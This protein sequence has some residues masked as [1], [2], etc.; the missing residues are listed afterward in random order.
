[1]K[2]RNKLL[3]KATVLILSALCLWLTGMA[4]QA[5]ITVVE[6]DVTTASDNCTLLG[7]EGTYYV[8]VQEALDRIN[9]IR[10]EACKEGVISPSTGKPLTQ[11]DYVEIKWSGDLEYIARIRAAEAALTIA[12]TRTNG[13]SCFEIQSPNGVR[14]YAEDL[15]WNWS[16]SMTEAIEQWYEEKEDWINQTEGA[17]TGHYTSMINPRYKYFAMGTFYSKAARY[18]NSTAGEFSSVS[19]LSESPLSCPGECVQMLEFANSSLTN[20]YEI[21]GT[22]TGQAGSTADLSVTTSVQFTKLIRGIYIPVDILWESSDS[23]VASVDA[24]GKVTAKYCGTADITASP[25]GMEGS[26]SVT[27]TVVHKKET[28]EAVDPTCTENGLTEGGHCPV[29]GEVLTAQEEIPAL[30]HKPAAVPGY[31]ATC[32][33]DGLT[34]GTKCSVC[35]EI[36]TE[37]EI[38][39]AT[40]HAWDDGFVTKEP[41]TEKEGVRTFTCETC[42]ETMTE[43]IP[44]LPKIAEIPALSGIYGTK[45]SG[46]TLSGGLV[47]R[48]GEEIPGSWSIEDSEDIPAVGTEASYEVIFAASGEDLIVSAAVTPSISPRNILAE[49][50]SAVFADGA[51]SGLV[52]DGTAKKPAV[53]ITDAAAAITERDYDISYEQNVI[54]GEAL[55]IIT[56]K[57][58]YTGTRTLGFEV[59]KADLSGAQIHL[60]QTR[61]IGDGTEKQPEV[62][63][64][65][66]ELL[67]SEEDYTVS[68]ADN[69]EPGSAVVHIEAAEHCNYR[70][71]GESSFTI[72]DPDTIIQ[73]GAYKG[74]G[75]ETAEIGAKVTNIDAEAFADCALLSDIRFFGSAPEIALDAFANV[76]ATAF[77]PADD[78]SWNEETMMQYGGNLVWV[79]WNPET[80]E[81]VQLPME[82]CRIAVAAGPFVYSDAAFEPAVV[83]TYGDRILMQG[84]DYDLAYSDNVNAGTAAVTV[85]GMGIYSGSKT[86]NFVIEKAPASIAFAASE[87]TKV[88]GDES[89]AL[90]LDACTTDSM[91]SYQSSDTAV[92]TVDERG[93][94]MIQGA[95]EANIIAAAPESDNYKAASASYKLTVDKAAGSLAFTSAGISRTYG[96]NVSFTNALKTRTTDG[97]ITYKSSNT[98]VAAVDAAGK[99]TVKGAGTAKITAAAAAGTNYKAASAAY[100]VTVAKAAN[101]LTASNYTKKSTGKA[102]SFTM[103][104][105]R[106]GG[107]KMTFTS[108]KA[109]VKVTSAGKVTIAAAFAG[110]ATITVKAA[111]SANYKAAT[112]K[113]TITVMPAPTAIKKA[114]NLSGR[115]M[116]LTWKKNGTATG[117]EIQ[118]A[119]NKGFTSNLKEVT[120]TKKTTVSKTIKGLT[121]G[122]TYYVRMRAYKTDGTKY[123]S[124]WSAVKK[125]KIAK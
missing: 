47:T 75:L 61:Y 110:K 79:G 84:T 119:R 56:A 81:I 16:K 87:I 24:A 15:A 22:Q 29:C 67:L 103:K 41:T 6:T 73:A 4:V 17:V 64:T 104:F 69:V 27:Y 52:Y 37:Q 118:Y 124:A 13:N 99:V 90:E 116:K 12:H 36:L 40:G 72:V 78:S 25:V 113:R 35:E 54:A 42:G 102:Q 68:Y 3:K 58:N 76:C 55:A 94:V 57:G 93:E 98:K 8:Q 1:M 59:A 18:Y 125:V 33:E 7:L 111:A 60:S 83:V 123:Y 100:T 30:G 28:D 39:L 2:Q 122:K 101:K 109:G 66:G 121:K 112:L 44:M 86:A 115:K 10:L 53:L 88:Y 19:G 51:V 50:I 114:V 11:S 107:A 77:Y 21:S 5:E 106:L 80:G 9:E 23:K 32:T 117:Y 26:A 34:D 82:D 108:N 71:F 91:L 49:E 96:T 62:T 85:S 92:A 38:I 48:A 63:V 70:G 43:A 97:K 105:S 95:G 120:V 74:T 46:L 89:F 45:V 65:Y 31:A 14:S 20:Q